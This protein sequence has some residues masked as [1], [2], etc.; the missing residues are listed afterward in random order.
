M[1]IIFN[2]PK[3][4]SYEDRAHNLIKRVRALG[5][6]RGVHIPKKVGLIGCFNFFTIPCTTIKMREIVIEVAKKMKL[7]PTIR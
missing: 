4:E 2:E 3:K 5:K 1:R 7:H 6:R